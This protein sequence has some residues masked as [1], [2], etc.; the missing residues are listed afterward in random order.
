MRN[1]LC[2]ILISTLLPAAAAPKRNTVDFYLSD[3]NAHLGQFVTLSVSHVDPLPYRGNI[4]NVVLY[5]VW[6]E[7]ES[8]MKSLPLAVDSSRSKQVAQEFGTKFATQPSD[9]KNLRGRFRYVDDLVAP[10]LRNSGLWYVG[11]APGA[12]FID[13]TTEG[14]LDT[15]FDWF[16]EKSAAMQAG[17]SVERVTARRS[18]EGDALADALRQMQDAE[19]KSGKTAKIVK[20]D[21]IPDRDKK[22]AVVEFI[23]E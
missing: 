7:S 4:P 23:L 18:M 9:Y 21:V 12:Y 17:K 1:L 10:K 2:L 20:Q 19:K 13:A 5:R 16:P 15:V 22:I 3:P 8:S 6:T 14:Q 11:I